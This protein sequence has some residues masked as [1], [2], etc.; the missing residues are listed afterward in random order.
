MKLVQENN[1]NTED[2]AKL[3]ILIKQQED[4]VEAM[5]KFSGQFGIQIDCLQT[6]SKQLDEQKQQLTQMSAK[7]DAMSKQ[8][9]GRPLPELCKLLLNEIVQDSKDYDSY[10]F[11][12]ERAVLPKIPGARDVEGAET[13]V[14]EADGVVQDF[15]KNEVQKVMLVQGGG[16]SGKSLY[17]HIL[18]R[19]MLKKIDEL[20]AIPIFINLPSL[21]D[22]IF[23]V[24]NETLKSKGFEDSEIKTLRSSGKK[25]LLFLDGYDEIKK[26]NNIYNSSMLK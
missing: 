18:I 26:Y 22:P 20:D 25:L 7:I 14:V 6:V 2:S 4:N 24:L 9:L 23:N 13:T 19:E 11:I 12:A 21:K 16:G 3:K 15:L 10:V 8:I 5:R 17:C 1:N